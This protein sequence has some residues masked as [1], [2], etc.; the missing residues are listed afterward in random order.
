MP[1][2]RPEDVGHSPTYKMRRLF[3]LLIFSALAAPVLVPVVGWLR[4][5]ASQTVWAEAGRIFGLA[6][7]TLALAGFAIAIAV[8]FGTVAAFILERMP[9]P[10]RRLLRGLV[11]AGLFVPLP[12]VAVAW[13]IVLGAWLP[14][15]QL[16]PGDVAWRPWSQGLVPAAWVHGIAGLPWVIWIVGAGLRATDRTLEE[17]ARLEGGQRTLI[18][19][20]LMPRAVLASLAAAGWVAVVAATEIAVTDAM[21]V[22]TFAEEVYTQFVSTS[23]GMAAAVAVT[24]PAWL[25][26]GIVLGWV[27]WR[28]APLFGRPG[29]ESGPPALLTA[30]PSIKVVASSVVWGMA[31]L[32]AGFPVAALVWKAGGG[33]TADGWGTLFL[34]GE[35]RKV[36]LSDGLILAGSM[37]SAIA[38]GLV[39]A[40]LAV[41][42]CDLAHGT[43]WFSR[44]LIGLCVTLAV[45]PGP[46][47]GLGLKQSIHTI[48][49]AEDAIMRTAGVAPEFPPVRSA[50]YDQPSPL[51]AGWATLIRLFPVA[52]VIVWPSIIAIPRELREAAALDG[53]GRVGTWRTVILPQSGRAMGRAALAVS[54]LVLGEVSASKLV[55]PQFRPS[56]VLRLFDQMHYGADSTVAA[57]CLLQLMATVSF[58]GLVLWMFKPLYTRHRSDG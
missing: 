39:A 2:A 50:L 36:A 55:N 3:A 6:A 52:V 24:L 16:A 45:T 18:R 25:F 46:L 56:Y 32:F 58:G 11:L 10:G 23:D 17:T 42:A 19:R 54:A 44:F 28:T 35:L 21:M 29:G 48:M 27:A 53:L 20:V 51:P 34:G 41:T 33:G 15:L 4:P 49:D 5:S 26:A 12:I 13:Q 40:G 37:A 30:S 57:L 1:D 47:V 9:I 8:P 7:T 43:R 22:R 31:A 14:P 38:V